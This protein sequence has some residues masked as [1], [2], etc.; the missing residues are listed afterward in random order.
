[1]SRNQ[2]VSNFIAAAAVAAFTVVKLGADDVHV[3]P[4][5]A[6]GDSLL[7]VSTDIPS[8]IG[9]RCDV[10]LSGAAD[11][12]Y[13]GTVV[14]GDLLTSDST[15]RAVSAAPAAGVN[16]RVIGVALVSGVVGDVG[17]VMIA[18]SSVQG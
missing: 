17:K 13:G 12:L 3:V 5:A 8:I 11:V 18:Q 15:G 2:Y 7:G 1:M 14:R 6:V 16:N 9:E 4:G 10:Q